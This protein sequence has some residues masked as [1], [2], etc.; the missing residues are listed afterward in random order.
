MRPAEGQNRTPAPEQ[1]AHGHMIVPQEAAG[2]VPGHSQ[3]IGSR[4]T[5]EEVGR[6]TTPPKTQVPKTGSTG[7]AAQEHRPVASARDQGRPTSVRRLFGG[8]VPKICHHFDSCRQRWWK[9]G[10]RCFTGALARI[11]GQEIGITGQMPCCL[12]GK[13]TQN[14]NWAN[15]WMVP[16]E[17]EGA[18][19]S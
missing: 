7:T 5:P 3:L 19:I 2:F 14:E 1:D 8:C 12:R 6:E 18:S 15:A 9:M 13:E 11:L 10:S 16:G 4:K 17:L